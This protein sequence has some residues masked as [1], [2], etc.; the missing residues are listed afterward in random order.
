MLQFAIGSSIVLVHLAVQT[1]HVQNH[2]D[3]GTGGW[4]DRPSHGT[5]EARGGAV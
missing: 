2:A 4:P 1:Y 5:H 3:E